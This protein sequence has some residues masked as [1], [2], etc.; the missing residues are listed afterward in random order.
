MTASVDE[1]CRDTMMSRQL[2]TMGN[3]RSSS[4]GGGGA[5]IGSSFMGGSS[6]RR[7]TSI[8]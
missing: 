1:S 6:S 2:R 3:L 4:H 5:R 8:P 7:M